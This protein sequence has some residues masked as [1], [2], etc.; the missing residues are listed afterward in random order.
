MKALKPSNIDHKIDTMVEEGVM[1]SGDLQQQ[2]FSDEIGGMGKGRR[3]YLL[4]S[5]RGRGS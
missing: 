4:H 2:C 3:L 1:M 5:S